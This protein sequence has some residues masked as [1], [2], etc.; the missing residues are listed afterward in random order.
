MSNTL[1][2]KKKPELQALAAELG[3]D[4]DGSKSDLEA[5][6][7]LYLSGHVELKGDSKFTK[8]F[9]SIPGSESPGQ[10][11]QGSQRRRS[12]AAKKT[13]DMGETVSKG[14]TRYEHRGNSRLR[15]SWWMEA[16]LCVF[17]DEEGVSGI[18][19]VKKSKRAATSATKS[20]ESKTRDILANMPSAV[21]SPSRVSNQ[22]ELATSHLVR[23]ARSASTSLQLHQVTSRVPIV[24]QAISNVVSVDG[25]LTVAELL[26]LLNKLIP[27]TYPVFSHYPRNISNLSL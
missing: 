2:S 7:L 20:A 17:S 25:I 23:R 19:V 8:Y 12:I 13:T 16:N 11:A 6:I 10:L 22:I 4:T 15:L 18:E 1:K 27:C 3:I 21:P 9:A 14:L 26:L 24:R 5:R